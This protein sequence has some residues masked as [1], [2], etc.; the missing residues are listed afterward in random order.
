LSEPN[1]AGNVLEKGN[2]CEAAAAI[3][4]SKCNNKVR[5]AE[6]YENGHFYRKS[7][8]LYEELG[9]QMKVGDLYTKM[10]N[11]PKAKTAYKK[12]VT[13]MV[14]SKRFYEAGEIAQ[15]KIT[16]IHSA[17]GY[18]VEGWKVNQRPNVCLNAY[19]DSYSVEERKKNIQ[20]LHSEHFEG[21]TAHRFID[22]LKDQLKKEKDLHND[23]ELIVYETV[24]R[25]A[26]RDK[27][28]VDTLKNFNKGELVTKDIMRFKQ[29]RRKK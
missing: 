9:Q 14:D 20:K 5:A 16:D 23:V 29:V 15:N 25:N 12:D 11:D 2:R 26:P 6:C 10:G 27:T 7:I 22:V 4:L 3:F 28:I 21:G 8:D 13:K 19:L 17:R 24:A 18:F 1:I